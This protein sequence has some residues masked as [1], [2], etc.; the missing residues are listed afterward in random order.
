MSTPG[1]VHV[2][3]PTLVSKRGCSQKNGVP[4]NRA[5]T[6]SFASKVRVHEISFYDLTLKRTIT[7]RSS[8][9]TVSGEYYTYLFLTFAC[10]VFSFTFFCLCL[11]IKNSCLPL[12]NFDSS[13]V[14]DV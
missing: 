2:V 4:V 5:H 13:S 6:Q 3:G 11:D 10:F 12:I 9:R 1:L 8:K 7:I 14:S